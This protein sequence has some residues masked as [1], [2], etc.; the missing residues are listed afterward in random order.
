MENI[1]RYTRLFVIQRFVKSRSHYNS[2]TTV[3]G[4]LSQRWGGGG[5]GVVSNETVVLRRWGVE[6]N[7]CFISRLEKVIWPP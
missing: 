1:V 3:R 7:V 4:C 2:K 5:G 6:T